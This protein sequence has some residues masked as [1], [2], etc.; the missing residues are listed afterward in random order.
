MPEAGLWNAKCF[1]G[2]L[3][4]SLKKPNA[5]FEIVNAFGFSMS[6]ILLF[7]LKII[8]AAIKRADLDKV[9]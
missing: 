8:K 6:R 5:C 7:R 3:H 4:A 1:D 9:H 2:A